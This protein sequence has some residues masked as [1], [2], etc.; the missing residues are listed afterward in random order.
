VLLRQDYPTTEASVR[1]QYAGWR[2]IIEVAN[3]ALDN[4][5]ALAFPG[6]RTMWGLLTRLAAKLLAFNLGIQLNRLFGRDDL[7]LATLFSC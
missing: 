3:A 7:A 1:R 2:Q 5:F 6:A 4:V